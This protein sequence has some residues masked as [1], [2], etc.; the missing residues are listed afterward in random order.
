MVASLSAYPKRSSFSSSP[1]RGLRHHERRHSSG[2]RRESPYDNSPLPVSRTDC[3]KDINA[4]SYDPQHLKAWYIPNELWIRLPP[5]LLTSLMALQHAGAAVLTGFER[6]EQL[7][8]SLPD[9][10]EEEEGGDG[11]EAAAAATDTFPSRVQK[12]EARHSRHDSLGSSGSASTLPSLTHS[13][14]TSPTTFAVTTPG[15]PVPEYPLLSPNT[16]TKRAEAIPHDFSPYPPPSTSLHLLSTSGRATPPSPASSI[17]PLLKP[18]PSTTT[19]PTDPATAYYHAE[20]SHLRSD[21]LVRLRHAAL[22][23][24]AEWAECKRLGEDEEGVEAEFEMW[25]GEVRERV[26]GLDGRGKALAAGR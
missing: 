6:L 12:L 22:R 1:G 4:F 14:P 3:P 15:S 18:F 25:W 16:T 8:T 20:L 11:L 7:G 19:V 2:Y 10:A 5:S 13:D 21:A 9:L 24:D 17:S 26:R 23:L